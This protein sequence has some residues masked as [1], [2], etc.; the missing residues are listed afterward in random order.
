MFYKEIADIAGQLNRES[1]DINQVL[2]AF[3]MRKFGDPRFLAS[4]FLAIEQD[5]KLTV[6]GFFGASPQEIGIVDGAISIFEDHPASESIRQDSIICRNLLLPE[7]SSIKPVVI[8]WPVES[9]ARILGS[10]V[11]ITDSQCVVIEENMEF[12]EALASLINGTLA[13][14]LER[15]NPRSNSRSAHK[16]AH[17]ET[18][19][20][21]QE[22]ILKLIA[23]GRT[24][25]D[26]AEILGY[27]ESLIRQETIKIYSI[28]NCNGRHEAAQM[29]LSNFGAASSS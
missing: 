19:S 27:S 6:K 21:R 12:L 16:P 14:T 4:F 23:E 7:S 22:V 18:L 11:S 2:E 25:G 10:I 1:L 28:L 13:R 3:C 29:Y 20:E 17:A 8:A 24:N 26:I 15:N 9:N 5:G